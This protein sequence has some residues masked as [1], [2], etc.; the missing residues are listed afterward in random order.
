MLY[1]VGHILTPMGRLQGEESH[2]P[3]RQIQA[4]SL[5]FEGLQATLESRT[6]VPIPVAAPHSC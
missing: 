4:A 3:Y 2:S 5:I 6:S 1:V